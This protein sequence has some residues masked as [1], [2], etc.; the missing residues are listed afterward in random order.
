M[1]IRLN[2]S[3]AFYNK[4]NLANDKRAFGFSFHPHE[5]ELPL[6]V[7]HI[8]EGKAW[9]VACFKANHRTEANFVSSQ[10]LA[11][12]LDQ[13]PMD[14]DMLED[15]SEDIQ[16]YAFMMYPTPSSTLEQPKTRILFVLDEP[17]TEPK[18]WRTL[19]LGLMEHFAQAKPDEACKDASRLF[20]GCDTPQYYV[21]Y[22]ARLPLSVAG[23]WCAP[24]ADRDEFARLALQ[25]TVRQQRGGTDLERCAANFLNHAIRK[26][27]SAG[28]G[29]RHQMFRNY[30]QWLYGLH[31][32]GWPISKGEIETS[33]TNISLAWGDKD[34]AAEGSLR[35]AE[36]NCIPTKPEDVK[37]TP[38]GEHLQLLKRQER[39]SQ[40][41][42]N[43]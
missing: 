34:K 21:D 32:G 6:L 40:G 5:V 37:V 35:W 20:Y 33:F 10:I 31:A 42:K 41:V 18:R 3:D 30:A 1:N 38:R 13:C 11:L 29:E 25:Y 12:D 28:K 17:V 8:R 23:G 24:Q 16:Q 9:T 14:M 7:K 39:Y 15:W 4:A 26:V 19:Q 2:L 22:E 27:S 36:A 43:G